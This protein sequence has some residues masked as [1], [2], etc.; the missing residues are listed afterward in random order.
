MIGGSF[1]VPQVSAQTSEGNLTVNDT[2]INKSSGGWETVPMT[3]TINRSGANG[4]TTVA[5]IYWRKYTGQGAG[6]GW[7][8]IQNYGT[9]GSNVSYNFTPSSSTTSGTYQFSLWAKN[10]S[11]VLYMIQQA[12]NVQFVDNTVTCSSSDYG[13]NPGSTTWCACAHQ[14]NNVG[15]LLQYSCS[16]APRT[17]SSC[18]AY[19]NYGWDGDSCEPGNSSC[20]GRTEWYYTSC[21]QNACASSNPNPTCTTY[22]VTGTVSRSGGGGGVAGAEVCLDPS[23]SGS[24]TSSSFRTTT[25]SNGGYTINNVPTGGSGHTVYVVPVGFTVSNNSQAIGGTVCETTTR[26]FTATYPTGGQGY[27]VQFERCVAG[28]WTPI[29]GNRCTT[30]CGTPTAPAPASCGNNTC[31]GNETCSNCPRDCGACPVTPP[32]PPP[33]TVTPGT[34]WIQTTGGDVH[35]NEEINA[36]GGPQ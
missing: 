12:A 10:G 16:Q 1:I 19:P 32:P 8:N 36:P 34:P 23:A 17:C 28:S 22:T 18:I 4:S 11:S 21:S 13:P 31:S 2:S 20:G 24:C 5:G 3:V 27:N 15:A 6:E 9:N 26:N 33:V 30:A 29:S 14:Q 25:N 35:S 7:T